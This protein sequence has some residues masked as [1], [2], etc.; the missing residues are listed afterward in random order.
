MLICNFEMMKKQLSHKTHFIARYTVEGI[1]RTSFF[2]R[3]EYSEA[4]AEKELKDNGVQN[5]L[6]VMEPY[7]PVAV[8]ENGMLF[9]GE[10]GFDITTEILLPHLQDGKEIIL[11]SFGG[12]LW[13][14]WRLYDTVKALGTNPSIGIIGTCASAATL[15][16]L[17][18]ENRWSTENSRLLIHNPWALAV[19]D[20]DEMLS[21][22]GNLR[23]EKNRIA[24]LYSKVSGKS[25]DELLALMKEERFMTSDEMLAYN[26]IT[27]IRG[28]LSINN[29]NLK[30]KE[31]NKEEIRDALAEQEKNLL[32]QIKSWFKGAPKAAI[33]QD[34]NG[35]DLDFGEAVETIEQIEVG[36]TAT[37]DGGPAEG[38]FVLSNGSTY[39][40]V[41]GE[42]TEIIIPE[43][44]DLETENAALKQ[45]LE[46]LKAKNTLNVSEVKNLKS[47]IEKTRADALKS[48]N[49]V[50]SDFD[51]FKNKFSDGAPSANVP[52]G[53]EPKPEGFVFKRK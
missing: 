50:K 27:K 1:P 9:R 46:T 31:M 3:D 28:D 33:F 36:M 26:F 11:D 18:T 32:G 20:D 16:L 35:V 7:E 40:F 53:D 37:V 39:V 25:V 42:V 17:A 29:N 21:E 23:E 5:F 49:K 2:S 13:E 45:E 14:G 52:S 6:F 24:N 12:S 38:E 15:L 48:L 47:E 10:V 19:G 4:A 8:G 34:V 41:A 30:N 51:I 43:G 44:E 22:G